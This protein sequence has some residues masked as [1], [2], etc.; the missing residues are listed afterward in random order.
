[1]I[2]VPD[3]LVIEPKIKMAVVRIMQEHLGN[4]IKHSMARNLWIT[5]TFSDG[6]VKLIIKDDGV[7]F[8]LDEKPGGLGLQNIRARVAM[9]SG[10]INIESSPGNGCQM[11]VSIP[12]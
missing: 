12:V 1:M 8:N 2:Q 4:V 9:L 7:G 3:D 11:E 10:H 5:L 6:R